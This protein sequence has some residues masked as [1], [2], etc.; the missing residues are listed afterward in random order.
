MGSARQT[1]LSAAETAAD[2]LWISTVR[3]LNKSGI[4]GPL[5]RL[6]VLAALARRLDDGIDRQ[7]RVALETG[8]TYASVGRC[9]HVSRQAARSRFQPP[10][11]KP[12]EDS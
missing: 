6:A 5:D 7:A 2:Q 10:T 11:P 3:Y 12:R 1:Q 8:A 9:L 4:T